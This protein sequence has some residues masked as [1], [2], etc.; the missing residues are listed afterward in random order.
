MLGIV[1]DRLDVEVAE[2]VGEDPLGDLT[3]LEHVRDARRHP[4]VV[5]E[6]VHRPVRVTDEVAAADV[7]PHSLRRPH[8]LALGA[9]VDRRGQH[10]GREHP[11]GHDL[12]G[13]VQVVDEKVEGGE[14]LDEPARDP[15]PLLGRDHAGDH[16][17]RP[18]PVDV[19]RLGVNGEGD[20]HRPDS[21]LGRLLAPRELIAERPQ[22]T[23]HPVAG[24]AGRP[25]T[26]SS[27]QHPGLS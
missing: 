26:S 9:E 23:H 4:Q 16:V 5:L 3:V 7:C 2:Q 12:G 25:S 18:G 20:A 8:P 17:E 13:A 14:P 19:G 15:L 6:H 1:V 27:S 10:L 24:L 11:V 21:Q 22:I